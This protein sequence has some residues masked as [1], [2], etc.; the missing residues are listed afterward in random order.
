MGESPAL[1]RA[2]VVGSSELQLRGIAEATDALDDCWRH[3]AA[4][5]KRL[6]D[7]RRWIGDPRDLSM[8]IKYNEVARVAVTTRLS[9][10]RLTSRSVGVFN[11]F[12]PLAHRLA[13]GFPAA[14][15]IYSRPITQS[16]AQ[17]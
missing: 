12:S 1:A 9:A 10:L 5:A 8:A 11:R 16:P 17:E 4:G 14:L 13:Y 3:S 6:G 7:A 15:R 2:R